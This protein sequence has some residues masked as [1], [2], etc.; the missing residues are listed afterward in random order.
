RPSPDTA[1]PVGDLIPK[2]RRMVAPRFSGKLTYLVAEGKEVKSG[3]IVARLDTREIEENKQEEELRLTML[4]KEAEANAAAAARD[5]MKLD[6][7][8]QGAKDELALRR[9]ELA[10]MRRGTPASELEDLTWQ[11]EAARK[12]YENARREHTLREGLL[13]K[14]VIR[15]V[16][17]AE[18]QVALAKAHKAHK[19]ADSALAI[20]KNGYSDFLIQ[21]KRLEVT[22]AETALAIIEAKLAHLARTSAMERTIAQADIDFSRSRIA[23][24]DK[25]VKAS[26]IPAP[27][28][29]VA[30]FQAVWTNG[31]KKKVQIGDEVRQNRPFMEVADVSAVV[32]RTDIEEVDIGRVSPGQPVTIRVESLNQ[33]FEGQIKSLG[34]LAAIKPNLVN[35]DGAPKVFEA[36]VETSARSATF[37]PGMT[38]DLETI[39]KRLPAALTVPNKALATVQGQTWVTVRH[40]DGRLER[41]RVECGDHDGER[42]VVTSGLTAG[43]AVVQEKPQ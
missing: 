15:P 1:K 40:P 25:R 4:E 2:E 17:L 11:A 14:G 28:P 39:V 8:R 32:I 5:R 7:E 37:R 38:V 23:I 24:L 36:L 21:A 19:V 27:G 16:D 18:H 29:G 43:E 41:R 31:Q 3:E 13:A 12:T 34:V 35:T 6:T 42:T 30:V 9:L 22:S 33:S 20:A 10:Q 26:A